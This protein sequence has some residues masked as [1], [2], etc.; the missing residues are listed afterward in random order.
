MALKLASGL[1]QKAR[2]DSMLLV[3]SD[4]ALQNRALGKWNRNLVFLDVIEP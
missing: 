4:V 3:G 1:V 2:P